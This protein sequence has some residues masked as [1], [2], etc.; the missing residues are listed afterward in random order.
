MSFSALLFVAIGGAAGASLRFS[1]SFLMVSLFGKGFP[2]GTLLV[3]II[4]S[5]LLGLLFSVIEHGIVRE[6]PWHPLIGVGFIGALT[7]F[8]T[9]SIDTLLMLQNGDW[10]KAILNVFLN[11]LVCLGAVWLGM[12]LAPNRN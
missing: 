8:S 11:V 7:T 9:F 5:F 1:L 12:Q 4:G 2:Y 6:M 10:Q 3:N